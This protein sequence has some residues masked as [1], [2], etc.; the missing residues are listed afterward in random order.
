VTLTLPFLSPT[1]C[2]ATLYRAAPHEK[3]GKKSAKF[4]SDYLSIAVSDKG[5]LNIAPDLMHK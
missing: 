5:I 4:Y 2:T 1:L 3:T